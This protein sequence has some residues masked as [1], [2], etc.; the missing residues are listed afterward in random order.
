MSETSVNEQDHTTDHASA[1][2]DDTPQHQVETKNSES[3]A[4]S[5]KV[6]LL[7]LIVRVLA[8]LP[9]FTN[10]QRD[11]VIFANHI[12]NFGVKDIPDNDVAYAKEAMESARS[13]YHKYAHLLGLLVGGT[14]SVGVEWLQHT[15]PEYHGI[16]AAHAGSG[17]AAGWVVNNIMSEYEKR[18]HQLKIKLV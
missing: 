12:F 9:G 3:K 8:F 11:D 4:A 6:T 16:R 17:V 1:S 14:I 2:D 15:Y 7:A 13:F 5:T 18:I 10:P